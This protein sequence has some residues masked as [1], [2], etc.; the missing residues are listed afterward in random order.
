MRLKCCC[1]Y[2][3]ILSPLESHFCPGGKVIEFCAMNGTRG[4]LWALASSCGKANLWSD[5]TLKFAWLLE[6]SGAGYKVCINNCLPQQMRGIKNLV[7]L[8]HVHQVETIALSL[9]F[10]IMTLNSTSKSKHGS[11]PGLSAEIETL[12][13]S[14]LGSWD[15]CR[16]NELPKACL[17][18][19][20][21]PFHSL[22]AKVCATRYGP[23]IVFLGSCS[24]NIIF[25]TCFCK[26]HFM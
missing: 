25:S 22:L 18:E 1:I 6:S 10:W 14:K 13:S 20:T 19:R 24:L 9:K 16:W 4:C 12:I 17:T 8:L 5:Y 3:G 23:L 11:P 15:F 7:V 26:K 21:R 2:L